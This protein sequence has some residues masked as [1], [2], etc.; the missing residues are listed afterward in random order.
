MNPFPVR[1]LF[2]R[3]LVCP[4]I[5]SLL[6]MG[7]DSGPLAPTY[8]VTDC[9][10]NASAGSCPVDTS[11]YPQDAAVNVLGN[12]GT[13]HKTNCSFAGWNTARTGAGTPP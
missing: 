6:L 12:T 1:S 5:G 7:C 9:A 10:N 13:L 4:A 2:I 3:L 8:M 11:K